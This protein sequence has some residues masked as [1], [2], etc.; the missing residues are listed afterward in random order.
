MTTEAGGDGAPH[1]VL[2]HGQGSAATYWDNVVGTLAGPYRVTVVDLPGHGPGARR[3]TV[4]EAAPARLAEALV[5]QLEERGIDRPHLVGLSLGGWVVLEAAARGYGAS[6]TALAPAGL[7]APGA[8]VRRER[9]VSNFRH[10][11]VALRPALPWLTTR[12]T[13]RRFGLRLN[14]AHPERVTPAQLLAAAHALAQAKAYTACDRAAVRA[15]FEGAARVTVPCTVAFGDADRVL[16]AESS[17]N[18]AL[19]PPGADWV[20]VPDCGH[21]MSWD[22]PDICVELIRATTARAGA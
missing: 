9:E 13:V 21:A 17:Q 22:Q 1:L 8:P 11:V 18:R 5:E 10:L 3:L 16:D 15:R 14:V 19:A 4:A 12:S 7:W 20:V 2:V 6:V